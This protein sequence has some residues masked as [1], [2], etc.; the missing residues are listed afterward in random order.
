MTS[1]LSDTMTTSE[2]QTPL[3][4]M[5]FEE[6]MAW[7]PENGRAEWVG[8]EI[9]IMSPSSIEHGLLTFFVAWLLGE[10]INERGLG[11][12]M[13]SPVVMRLT[14]RPSGREPD[15][16]FL[17]N[18]HRDRLQPTYVDGPVDLAVEVVSPDSIRRDRADKFLEYEAGGVREYWVLDP[19][20]HEA[21]FY[22]LADDERYR[23]V[24][25][26][27]AGIYRSTVLPGFWLQT[28]WLWQS[29]HPIP[30]AVREQW[31]A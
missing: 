27:P 8:G 5:T 3:T 22:V 20:R 25:P 18:E 15:I 30:S 24:D 16:F 6:F 12:V 4:P 1:S 2:T 7:E 31:G 28:A 21:L 9:E 13:A 19:M 14:S 29:P 26:D 17:A 23:R 10:Y 11:V